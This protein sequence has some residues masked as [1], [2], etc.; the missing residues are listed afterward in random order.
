MFCPKSNSGI[1]EIDLIV[2]DS[3]V[4]RDSESANFQFRSKSTVFQTK[5]NV[6]SCRKSKS[7]ESVEG[8]N[9]EEISCNDIL[10][11][12]ELNF[13]VTRNPLEE[14]GLDDDLLSDSGNNTE[15]T[16]ST[17]GVTSNEESKGIAPI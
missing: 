17:Q 8:R 16:T 15:T 11:D 2:G 4:S 14:A 9:P 10:E 3:L 7:L 5:S 6:Q 1:E 13:E 12:L